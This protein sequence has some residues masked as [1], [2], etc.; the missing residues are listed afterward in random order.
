MLNPYRAAE[1]GL[2]DSVICPSE[3]RS[4]IAKSLRFFSEK[5]VSRPARKHGNI[6]L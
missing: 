5:Q 2:I 3:T 6:P 4:T 1:R